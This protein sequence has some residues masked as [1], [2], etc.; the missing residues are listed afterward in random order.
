MIW[1]QQLADRLRLP[2]E[3]E[4]MRSRRLLGSGVL[5]AGAAASLVNGLRYGARAW[6]GRATSI[7][8]CSRDL[9]CSWC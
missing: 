7:S 6:Y 8:C 4:A 5:L 9:S 2:G 1:Y 3:D